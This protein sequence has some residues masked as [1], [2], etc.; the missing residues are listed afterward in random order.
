[1]QNE[2]T[3]REFSGKVIGYIETKPNGDKVV[4][5][6]YRRLLGTYNKKLNV[7]KDFY[8]RTVARGDLSS[9]LLRK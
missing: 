2:E 3:I 7:T 1:M 6:F 5:D 8:G 4:R 9:M